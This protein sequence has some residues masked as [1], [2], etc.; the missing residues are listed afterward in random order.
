L[1]LLWRED[2][3]GQCQCGLRAESN[4]RGRAEVLDRKAAGRETCRQWEAFLQSG[5]RQLIFHSFIEPFSLDYRHNYGLLLMLSRR[6]ANSQHNQQHLF[7]LPL[8]IPSSVIK[9]LVVAPSPPCCSLLD[10]SFF[11]AYAPISMNISVTLM[12]SLALVS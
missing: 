12:L 11:L 1:L 6:H 5:G 2:A 7:F 3:C 10:S 9:F 4:Q 8:M